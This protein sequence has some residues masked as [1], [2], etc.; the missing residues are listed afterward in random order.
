MQERWL[1]IQFY[2]ICQNIMKMN[3]DMMD[4]FD[5]IDFLVLFDKSMPK[6]ILKHLVQNMYMTPYFIPDQ[7][8]FLTLALKLKVP[9]SDLIKGTGLSRQAIFNYTKHNPEDVTYLPRLNE[10]Q[11]KQIRQFMTA[12]NKIIS[13]G[14]HYAN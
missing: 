5:F 1:E 4:V 14:G 7:T 12:Y 13:L 6:D 11:H 3:N 9:Y 10:T 2:T 8:E